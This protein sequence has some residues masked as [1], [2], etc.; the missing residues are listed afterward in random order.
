MLFLV[1]KSEEKQTVMT[2]IMKAVGMN[3]KSHG[4]VLSLPVSD[5]IGL[6]D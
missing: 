4:I 2:A 6:A 1:V 5:A 3:T